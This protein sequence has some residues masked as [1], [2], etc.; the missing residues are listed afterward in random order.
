MKILLVAPA[1]L[2][3]GAMPVNAQPSVSTGATTAVENPASTIDKALPSWMQFGGEY[4]ARFE[5]YSGGSFKH[6]ATDDYLLSRL[7]L[8]M[9]I[10][11]SK[12][13][14]FFAEGMDARALE[15]NPAVPTYQNT[16]DIRQAYADL[17][18]F[19]HGIGLR[20][21]RQE[22]VYG[23]GRLIGISSWSNTERNWDAVRAGLHYHGFRADLFTGSIVIPVTGTWDHHQQ[24]NNLHGIYGGIDRFGPRLV[25]EPYG[26]WRLQHALR[27]EAGVVANLNEKVGG[28][29]VAGTKLP[30]G[31]DYSTEI[32][33]EWGSLGSDRIQTW[34]GHWGG[35]E[36][37]RAPFAPRLF[38]EF[39]FAAGDR[40]AADGTRGTF[41]Q[42]F[43]S[44]HDKLGFSD[45]VGWRNIKDLRAGVETKPK[46]NVTAVFEYNNWYLA[47]AT[48]SLYS[49]SGTA[50]FRSA[51]GT[52]GTHVGQEI[53]LTGTWTF[54]KAFTA[55][56]GVAHIFPGEFLKAV[57]AGNP[58]TY[59]YLMMVYKF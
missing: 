52:A 14:K 27:N 55:G 10:Q 36:A 20:A 48:D 44:G 59:P 8:Q 24:S 21:G 33:R 40:N 43:P 31:F 26:M 53:D 9:T 19:D 51:T 49:S 25:I 1:L 22:M 17:G 23:E 4:R 58:Y 28:V 15:K 50:V 39:N 57:T 7:K 37:I 13:L 18:D 35:G 41:D 6:N 3:A 32:V 5:G 11:A 47:S 29:R 34:A 42:L 54:A 46:K 16:W 2:L 45:Q 38:A 56:A 30:G 12:W